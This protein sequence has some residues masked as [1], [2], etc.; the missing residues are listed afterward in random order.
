MSFRKLEIQNEYRPRTAH[1]PVSFF[2]D[3]IGQSLFYRRAA[4]Y[5]SSSVFDLFREEFIEFSTRGGKINLVC[6]PFISEGDFLEIQDKGSLETAINTS[7]ISQINYL[8]DHQWSQ[9]PVKFF[10]SLVNLGILEVRIAYYA[11]G[12]LFHDKTGYFKDPAG[13]TIS[14]RGSANET[15]MGWSKNGNYESIEAFHS[16]IEFDKRRVKSHQTYLD[17]LWEMNVEGV[18]LLSLPEAS[19]ERLKLIGHDDIVSCSSLFQPM[20]REGN[21]QFV[22]KRT[23]MPHQIDS[24]VDWESHGSR[25]IL[26]H[27]TGSGKTVTAIE[28]PFPR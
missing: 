10:G 8:S 5:F 26:N 12:G 24:I 3:A 15:F 27:A 25:G 4:G 6:S 22:Q 13:N 9:N 2:R 16:W 19:K 14:F 21:H 17:D 7:I 23:L 1:T 20:G 11:T 28:P 18:S